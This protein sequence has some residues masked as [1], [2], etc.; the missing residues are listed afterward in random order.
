MTFPRPPLANRPQAVLAFTA[1]LALGGLGGCG[2][3]S[4]TAPN[5][6]QPGPPLLLAFTT[7][8]PPSPNLNVTD[9]WMKAL[10][11]NDP[12][13]PIPNVDTPANESS[14]A[15]SGDGTKMAFFTDRFFI[16]TLVEIAIYDVETGAIH[17]PGPLKLITNSTLNPSLS[18]D[19]RYLAFQA[20]GAGPFDQDILMIDTAADTLVQMPNINEYAATDFDP[21]VNGDGTLI[22]F[23]TNGSKSIGAFDI[24][25]YSVP[26][27]SFIA[28]PNLNS[29]YNELA[30]SI[31]RDGRYIA[32]QTGNPKLVKGLVDVEVYD[33]QLDTLLDLPGANTELAEV[34]PSI[35]P[36]G[37]YLA[38]ATESSGGRDIKL[39]DIQAKHLIPLSGVN[40][41][42]YFDEMPSISNLPP[43]IYHATSNALAARDV[44]AG[45]MVSAHPPG[46]GAF[47]GR[48]RDP[49]RK[50]GA[51]VPR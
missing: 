33:R 46:P 49:A 12:A 18:Y 10:S 39:Y 3:D 4:P 8:R 27:D 31:S 29:Y 5:P 19:G 20:Q 35:S 44:A 34:Q 17:I 32:F 15:L 50:G 51:I 22:A 41:P 30:A 45:G 47:V 23:A 48:G 2:T 21:S 7:N 25:L 14:A 38:Y 28:L 6:A 9:L 42:I 24:V 37:R 13:V 40:D 11:T 36:D 26:G 1:L 43:V 16:G